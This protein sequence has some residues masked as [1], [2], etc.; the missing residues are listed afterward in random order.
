MTAIKQ[1][2]TWIYH[3]FIHKFIKPYILVI[4]DTNEKKYSRQGQLQV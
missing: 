3:H 2:A 1:W 4:E